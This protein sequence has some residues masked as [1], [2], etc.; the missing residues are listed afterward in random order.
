MII[1][2]SLT[3]MLKL[4]LRFQDF[5]ADYGSYLWA[6]FS[7]QALSMIIKTTLEALLVYNNEMFID[8]F[9][10]DIALYSILYVISKIV[11]TIVPMITQLSCLIFGWIR[12]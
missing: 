9:Q 4:R 1:F 10:S 5:Y 3:L 7:V 2:I 6:V 11:S 12:C 8:L